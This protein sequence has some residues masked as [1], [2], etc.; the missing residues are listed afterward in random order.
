[1]QRLDDHLLYLPVSGQ[2]N[3]KLRLEIEAGIESIG[4]T[5]REE[6]TQPD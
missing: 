6:A 3:S 1:V 5:S 4:S 2:L